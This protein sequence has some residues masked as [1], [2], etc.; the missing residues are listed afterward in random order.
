MRSKVRGFYGD[1]RDLRGRPRPVVL[2]KKRR[3]M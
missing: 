1:W 3:E 2:E